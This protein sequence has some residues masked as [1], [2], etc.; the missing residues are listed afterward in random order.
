MNP[1][2]TVVVPCYKHEP[3][4]ADCIQ[5][6]INQDYENIELIIVDDASPDASADIIKSFNQRLKERFKSYLFIERVEN[7][8]IIA[9][10]NE[11][12]GK[13][14]GKY[15]RIIASDDMLLP[16][17]I[18]SKVNYL[19]QNPEAG[20]VYS[21]GYLM[22][23]E[24]T[25]KSLTLAKYK[26]FTDVN[27][28]V[29]TSGDTFK[30]LLI[31][32]FIPAPT[33]LLRTDIVKEVG[34]YD[35]KYSFEDYYMWL[36]VAKRYRIGYCNLPTVLYRLTNN[37]LSRELNSKKKMLM[38]H[39]RLLNEFKDHD[40]YQSVELGLDGIY[41]EYCHLLFKLSDQVEFINYYKKVKRKPMKL[42][43]KRLLIP[44][45]SRFFL[46]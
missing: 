20:L 4:V 29:G 15:I 7:R 27:S 5:S 17:D 1:L 46:H 34:G 28:K 39:I 33:V 42:I 24:G 25:L 14:K 45:K 3:Y 6:I 11:S 23:E 16:E 19:E 12:L 31:N 37:S 38:D 8:G 40:N 30:E 18:S 43:I 26:K 21:D 36:K 35:S 2:V 41:N 32:N 10:C 44:I 9:N 22:P 13:A